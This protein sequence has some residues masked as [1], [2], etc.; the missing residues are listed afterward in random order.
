MTPVSGAL[1][2]RAMRE[3]LQR[4]FAGQGVEVA[5]NTP[6]QFQDFLVADRKKW[7]DVIKAAG[8]QPE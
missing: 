1:R 8:I 4:L 6:A 2:L 5:T 3:S 7:A